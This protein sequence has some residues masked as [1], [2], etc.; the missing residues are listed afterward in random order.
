M[1]A[2]GFALQ[3]DRFTLRYRKGLSNIGRV[4]V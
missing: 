3:E 2:A 4:E 1:E